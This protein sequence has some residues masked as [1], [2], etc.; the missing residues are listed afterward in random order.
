MQ[1]SFLEIN[2]PGGSA[3]GSDILYHEIMGFKER[4]GAKIVAALLDVAASGGYYIALPADSIVAH[5]TTITGSVGVIFMVPKVA[6]LMDKLGV[7]VEVNKSGTEKDM[8]SPFRPS[9]RDEQIIMQELTER[10][11]R[12]FIDLVAKH[13]TEDPQILSKISTARIYLAPE[14]LQLK[15]VDRIGYVDDALSEAKNLA[16]LPKGAKVVV[17]RRSTYPD[18][19]I[20]NTSTSS[21]IGTNGSLVDLGLPDVI[22]HLNPGFY[23][24]WAPGAIGY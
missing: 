15:L 24:L 13:R 21:H 14:A 19:N 6:V 17:Y 10:M 16:G 23:Y 2:S 22:P 7:A 9:T 12:R 11:G 20:Y 5:P 4:T 8:G 3:T 1:R 18:D